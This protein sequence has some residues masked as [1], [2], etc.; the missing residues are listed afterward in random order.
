M[1]PLVPPQVASVETARVEVGAAELEALVDDGTMEE[2][3]GADEEA[4]TEDDA[5]L[6]PQ[7]PKPD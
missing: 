7:V 3:A 5:E 2:E 6:E 4:A 1:K